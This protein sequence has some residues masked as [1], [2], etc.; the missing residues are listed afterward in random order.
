M[1]SPEEIKNFAKLRGLK[2]HQEEK[3]YLQC[4]ILAILYRTVGESLVFKGG[5]ALFLLQGLD[6]FSED[7]DFTAVQKINWQNAKRAIVDG[8]ST[9]GI[10]AVVSEKKPMTGEAITVNAKG[11]LY[12]TPASICSVRVEISL[13]ADVLQKPVVSTYAPDYPDIL[14]F[15]MQSLDPVEIAAEKV[16]AIMKRNYARDLYDLHFLIRRG[17]LPQQG[18]IAR[19]MH[20]YKETF[21]KELFR[22]KVMVMKGAWDS[23]LSP[24]LF[25]TVPDFGAVAGIVLESVMQAE[26]GIG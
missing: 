17:H 12:S 1:R 5:T 25:G 2:P 7:L 19:K 21:S 13:R 4:A 22:A 3:R 10:E 14:P 8:L 11:P 15:T 20:Y 24:I 16:R 6:R 26:A 9:I 23:E 18:L